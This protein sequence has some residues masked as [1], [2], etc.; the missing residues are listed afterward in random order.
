VEDSAQRLIAAGAASERHL[1]CDLGELEFI[2]GWLDVSGHDLPRLFTLFGVVPNLEPMFVA[3]LFRELL[4]PGDVLLASVHLVPVGNGLSQF[5]AMEKI[6][7][8]Y[9]NLETLAWLREAMA[10]WKL[11]EWMAEPQIVT[12]GHRRVPCICGLAYWNSAE[13]YLRFTGDADATAD[14]CFELFFS[15][16][17]TPA[18]FEELLRHAGVRGEML[19][20]TACREEA[21]W[22]IRAA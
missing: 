14:P 20:I 1:V 2:K 9:K 11:N 15:M 21:I 12:S 19:A 10:Q 4:R 7:P 17:Y 8:Q 6:E 16:R 22:A 18:V 5:A 3:R 13:T